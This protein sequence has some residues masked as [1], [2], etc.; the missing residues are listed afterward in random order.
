MAYEIT[1][2]IKGKK[3]KVHIDRLVAPVSKELKSR[4]VKILKKK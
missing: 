3:V 1:R 2:G 4:R